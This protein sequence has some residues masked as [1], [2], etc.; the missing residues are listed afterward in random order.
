MFPRTNVL[1]YK[2]GRKDQC[3]ETIKSSAT[4]IK[5]ELPED[6]A[7]GLESRWKDLPRAALENPALKAHPS[8]FF[9]PL[10]FVGSLVSK[11][12]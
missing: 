3:I 2:A 6:I 7:K 8:H 5:F 4:Q 11:P 9:Q 10:I 12:E 1:L